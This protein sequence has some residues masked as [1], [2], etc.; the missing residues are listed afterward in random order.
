V[1]TTINGLSYQ[2][3]ANLRPSDAN[4]AASATRVIEAV[5]TE[6]ALYSTSGGPP[7]HTQP[8]ATFFGAATGSGWGPVIDPRVYYDL[9][10]A[11]PRFW[12][13]AVQ[14]RSSPFDGRFYLSISRAANPTS[15]N[16]SAWCHY[17][18]P[19]VVYPGTADQGRA[20][21]P[22]LGFGADKYALS[23]PHF[24]A[25]NSFVV[26][27]FWIGDK[28][29]VEN[30]ATSCKTLISSVFSA[31]FVGDGNAKIIH[32][33]QHFTSPSSFPGHV[34][35]LYMVSTDATPTSTYRVWRA[36][37]LDPITI[38]LAQATGNMQFTH[39]PP[40][41]QPA[42][43][44]L[45]A[46]SATDSRI[47]KA[48]GLGDRAWASHSVSC[49]N[50]AL[51]NEACVRV[52]GV[53]LSDGGVFPFVTFFQ[54]TTVGC[55]DE[56]FCWMPAVAVDGAQ[57]TAVAFLRSSASEY[58]SASWTTKAASVP[59]YSTYQTIRTGTCTRDDGNSPQT[60]DFTGAH[61]N[62]SL[63]GFWLTG[64]S[65]ERVPTQLDPCFWTTTVLQV[66]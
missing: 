48:V 7:I 3:A 46:T 40:A 39:P 36:S 58:L 24:R 34:N 66:N 8:L 25:N 33:V 53:V 4:A 61:P 54:Q 38:S 42:S 59:N 28:R 21:Y 55:G 22:M 17:S 14:R 47:L 13:V 64:E 57:R 49:A 60:G 9:N 10:A 45:L 29:T 35:P 2:P 52:I 18:A 50:G 62:S 6:I 15:L 31:S 56:V 44:K 12:V 16:S 41:P 23:L 20:D 37:N 26:T 5:N 43:A 65:A 1:L 51:P 27:Q 11:N 30:N 19:A 32:P 63:S